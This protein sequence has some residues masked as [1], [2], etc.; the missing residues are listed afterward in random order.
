MNAVGVDDALVDEYGQTLST[1]YCRLQESTENNYIRFTGLEDLFFASAEAT[2]AFSTDML[3]DAEIPQPIETIRTES[4]QKCR[5][6]L[7]KVGGID[8][9]HLRQLITDKH[10]DTLSLYQGQSRFMLEDLASYMSARN[11][12]GKQKKRVASSVAAEMIAVCILISLVSYHNANQLIEEPRLLE[13][14]RAPVPS[15]YPSL[16]SCVSLPILPLDTRSS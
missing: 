9:G 1:E 16:N 7:E 4:A 2:A 10:Q 15:P 5:L 3:S 11:M 6:L 14:G 13:P 12:G 8:R